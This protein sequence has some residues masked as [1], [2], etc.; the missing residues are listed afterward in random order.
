[1]E[2]LIR[3]AESREQLAETANLDVLIPDKNIVALRSR[4]TNGDFHDSV[5]V[6]L[7]LLSQMTYGIYLHFLSLHKGNQ[8]HQ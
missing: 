6:R 2:Q 8:G 4:L 5:E 7:A 1:L 3:F